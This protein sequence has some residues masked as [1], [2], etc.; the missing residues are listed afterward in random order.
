MCKILKTVIVLSATML[1]QQSYAQ[2]L[3]LNDAINI[4]LK[5]SL[6]VQLVKNDIE[7]ATISNTY[8]FAGGLPLVTGNIADNEQVTS[9]NQKLNTGTT[10]QRNNAAANNLSANVTGSIILFNGGRIVATKQRL[11]A[12]QTQSTTRLTSQVQNIMAA[13]LTSYYDVV[14]QQQYIKTIDLSI[15]AS[16]Q[17]LSIVK[18]RQSVGLANNAD[19][20]Q[21][22]IDLNA[23]LQS[24][25]AQALVVNQAKTGLLRLLTLNPDSAINIIDT[26]LVDKMPIDL[27]TIKSNIPKSADVVAADD[28]IKINQLIVKETNAQRYPTIRANTG[29]NFT[30]NQ[31]AAGQLLL[32][33]NYGPT[34][35]VSVAIPI[36]NGNIFKKQVQIANVNV[37]NATIQKEILLRDL[38]AAVSTQYQAYITATQQL[39]K[40]KE[41]YQLSAQLL[42]LVLQRFQLKQATIVDVKNAQQSFEQTGYRLTNVSYAAKA[43][44]I[45]LKRISNQL[46]L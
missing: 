32:N 43:A 9:V 45:E 1:F 40:E 42:Q 16:N 38:D 11:A 26:I 8:G 12:L 33:Q 20:F 31:A 29:Y 10:I 34:V 18:T 6:D 15:E 19:L 36:F 39:E 7:V 2:T 27:N 17:Q 13:V 28:Q 4:A 35:G 25:Q 46:S 44:E 14:R 41:N 23:L 3:S 5:N 22:Q 37:R 21:A 30:R 24:K